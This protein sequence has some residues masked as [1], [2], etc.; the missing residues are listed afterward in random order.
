MWYVV[1]VRGGYETRVKDEL[2]RKGKGEAF[3]VTR[4]KLH[5]KAGETVKVIDLL[6]PNYVFIETE[7]DHADFTDYFYKVKN[8]NSTLVKQIRHDLIG[9]PPLREEEVA[10]LERLLNKERLIESSVGFIVDD[11]V[12]VTEGP[13]AGLESFIKF[14]D[15]HKRIAIL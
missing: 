6:F 5:R 11:K 7:M 9:T 14:I 15:R 12:V 10:F 1:F 4:E 13:L 2:N 8:E 3:V